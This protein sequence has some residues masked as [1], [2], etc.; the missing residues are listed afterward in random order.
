MKNTK[1]QAPKLEAK[2]AAHDA[3]KLEAKIEAVQL[4]AVVDS[5]YQ[6]RQIVGTPELDAALQEL[7]NNIAQTGLINPITVRRNG[8]GF[9]LVAGHRRAAAA[10]LAGL[11]TVNAII[12]EMSDVEAESVLVSENLFRQDLTPI[13]E[14]LTVCQ[15]LQNMDIAAA[16]KLCGKSERWIYRRASLKNLTDDWRRIARVLAF[17]ASFCEWLARWQADVQTA[18]LDDLFRPDEGKTVHEE[19]AKLTDDELRGELENRS[20]FEPPFAPE[21]FNWNISKITKDLSTA[22]WAEHFPSWCEGCAMRSDVQP[23]LLNDDEKPRCQDSKCYAKK[24]EEFIVEVKKKLK[25][26]YG[27]V[28]EF[29]GNNIY[30]LDHSDE[31][32][33]SGDFVPMVCTSEGYRG[34][35]IYVRP[36]EK[37][38]VGGSDG[39]RAQPSEKDKKNAAFVEAVA[40]LIAA[41]DEFPLHPGHMYALA[42][43]L[44]ISSY[45][46]STKEIPS[47]CC[48]ERLKGIFN[49]INNSLGGI[50]VGFCRIAWKDIQGSIARLLRIITISGCEREKKY[51]DYFADIFELSAEAIAK[52]IEQQA[53]GKGKRK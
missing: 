8:D 3:P 48:I 28:E 26:E 17:P 14:G 9:E 38:T 44:G 31:P 20:D 5:P 21:D 47:Y 35:V 15:L 51:A 49:E 32:P 1:K 24:I 6:I 34:R 23:E 18:L 16:A 46:Y 11:E 10:R 52:M 53:S 39:G 33:T 37:G 12:T 13:E 19:M 43:A 2:P 27:K 42:M 45:S 50:A 41:M 36:P 25:A 40:A 4:S 7:A 29:P 22:P 30:M